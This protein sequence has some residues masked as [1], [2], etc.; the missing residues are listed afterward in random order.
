MPS[1]LPMPIKQCSYPPP[2]T[3]PG[4]SFPRVPG[5]AGLGWQVLRGYFYTALFLVIAFPDESSAIR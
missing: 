5:N 1:M 2:Q 4:L 3:Q